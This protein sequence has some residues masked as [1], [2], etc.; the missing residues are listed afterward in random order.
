MPNAIITPDQDAVVCEVRIAAPPERIFQALTSCDQLMSW[1]TGEGGPCRVKLWEM[2][3]RV[4]GKWRLVAADPTGKV[5]FNKVHEIENSGDIVEFDP[6]RLLALTWF[7]NAHAIPTHRSLVRWELT[8]QPAGTL[9]RM[10]HSG[11]K[12]LPGGTGYADGWPHVIDSLMRFF[13]PRFIETHFLEAHENGR[14]QR[15]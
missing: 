11:L 1:W 3:P 12:D 15:Q 10:T 14:R 4:G 8:L 13:E 6:P 2:D 5:M 7:S 9:V